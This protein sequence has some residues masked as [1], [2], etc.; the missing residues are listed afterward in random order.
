MSEALIRVI[1]EQQNIIDGLKA[2]IEASSRISTQEF[3]RREELFEAW[4]KL[5]HFDITGNATD[6]QWAKFSKI[7]HECRMQMI[8]NGYCLLC[9]NFVCECDYD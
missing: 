3:K 9:Y 5:L 1:A 2:N 7:R 6:E 8:N 4:A